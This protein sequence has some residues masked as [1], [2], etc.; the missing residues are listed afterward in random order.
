MLANVRSLL[1][2][3]QDRGYA[4]G[5][6]NVYNLEGVQAVIGAAEQAGSPAIL[7]VH[8]AALHHGGQP[9][10][11]LCLAAARGQAVSSVFIWIMARLP[12]TFAWHWLLV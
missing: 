12:A 6:F 3:A 1:E 11:A 8:P 4:V 9:L 5:A 10:L 7:Q 2:Q